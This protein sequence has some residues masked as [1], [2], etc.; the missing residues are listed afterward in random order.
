MKQGDE[1]VYIAVGSN[2]GDR[3]A[4]LAAVIRALEAEPEIDVVAA[5]PVFETAAVGPGDQGSYLNAALSLETGLAADALLD[6]LQKI[7]LELGRDRSESA[8]RWG[9]RVVDLD[10]LF[11]GSERIETPRLIVPHP[12]AHQRSFVMAPMA[13]LAPDFRHPVL[14]DTMRSL[15]EA[16]PDRDGIRL[17]R[18]P[19][20]WPSA[21]VE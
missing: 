8:V 11:F 17:S 5:S 16:L 15:A 14:G 13:R 20:G 7:E 1:I 12:R 2:L 9:P 4:I 3:T 19:Q 18:T 10:I 21:F 6:V